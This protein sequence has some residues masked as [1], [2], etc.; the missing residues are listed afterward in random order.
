MRGPVGFI[1]LIDAQMQQGG[2][3]LEALGGVLIELRRAL[4]KGGGVLQ[5]QLD[6]RWSGSDDLLQRPDG[7][8]RNG[9]RSRS[10]WARDGSRWR[11]SRWRRSG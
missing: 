2:M 5:L 3:T 6:I 8:G 1:D 11:G 9:L 10:G 7:A 4:V